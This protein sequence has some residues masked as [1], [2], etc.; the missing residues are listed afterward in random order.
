MRREEVPHD[1]LSVEA[2]KNKN[3]MQLTFQVEKK[4]GIKE[5]PVTPVVPDILIICDELI[6]NNYAII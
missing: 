2:H 5:L 4:I 3:M 6:L 1:P